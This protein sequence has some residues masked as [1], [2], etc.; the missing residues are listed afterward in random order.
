M[1]KITLKKNVSDIPDIFADADAL[2]Q[3]FLNIILNAVDS[4]QDGGEI[5]ISTEY[6]SKESLNSNSILVTIVDTGCGIPVDNL[7]NIFDPFFSTKKI[8]KGTGLGLAISLGI[9][10]EHGGNITVESEVGKGSKFVI[11][12]QV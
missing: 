10:Q 11:K 2:S 1:N 8:G 12:L 5:S 4:M 9:I 7:K 6:V 3:V